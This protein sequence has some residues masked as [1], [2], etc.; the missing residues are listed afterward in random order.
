MREILPRH[1]ETVIGGVVETENS[2]GLFLIIFFGAVF[3]L[4]I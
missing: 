1:D 4:P 3:L 2:I